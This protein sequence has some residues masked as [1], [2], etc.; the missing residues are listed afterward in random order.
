MECK[1][2]TMYMTEDQIIKTKE[3][4][5]ELPYLS[6]MIDSIRVYG[7]ILEE[8]VYAVDLFFDQ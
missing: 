2:V 6:C 3:L 1:T 5:E 4:C 7:R 8:D